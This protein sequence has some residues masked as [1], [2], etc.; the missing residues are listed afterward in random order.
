MLKV[1]IFKENGRMEKS[2]TDSNE[3]ILR[4][5]KNRQHPLATCREDQ[6]H[7]RLSPAKRAA[8]RLQLG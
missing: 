4:I 3:K 6:P 7:V 8:H 2:K 5:R 1:T